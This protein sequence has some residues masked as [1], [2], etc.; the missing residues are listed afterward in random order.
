MLVS[1]CQK[2]AD[3]VLQKNKRDAGK[4]QRD[5][6]AKKRSYSRPPSRPCPNKLD[7]CQL[8]YFYTIDYQTLEAFLKTGFIFAKTTPISVVIRSRS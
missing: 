5:C 3:L 7:I 8:F 2:N 4:N 6:L 1:A